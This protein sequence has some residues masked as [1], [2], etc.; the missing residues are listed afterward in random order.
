MKLVL[1]LSG[2]LLIASCKPTSEF[3]LKDELASNNDGVTNDGND[4]PAIPS[5]PIVDP[6]VQPPVVQP[7]VVSPPV[8][9]APPV[10]Q[11]PVVTEPPVVIDPPVVTPPIVVAPPVVTP[12]VV[13]APPV[14]VTPP[15]VVAPPV[16]VTPPV[17]VAPP[18]V[19]APPVI[20]TPPVTQAPIKLVNNTLSCKYSFSA[21]HVGE[22]VNVTIISGSLSKLAKISDSAYSSLSSEDK[23]F[24]AD[25]IAN[26]LSLQAVDGINGNV[27]TISDKFLVQN[28]NN[29]SVNVTR[30]QEDVNLNYALKGDSAS[31]RAT[32][33]AMN[34]K[35]VAVLDGK[36]SS[37]D[38]TSLGKGAQIFLV[39]V[40]QGDNVT[41]IST[42]GVAGNMHSYVYGEDDKITQSQVKATAIKGSSII[43]Y[44]SGMHNTKAFLTG[45]NISNSNV[46][47]KVE[48]LGV[49]SGS[50]NNFTSMGDSNIFN[51]KIKGMDLTNLLVD[52]TCAGKNLVFN[53]DLF[54]QRDTRASFAFT[55]ESNIKIL[56]TMTGTATKLN[57]SER[58][59]DSKTATINVIK[60]AS[61]NV[62]GSL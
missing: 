47:I 4:I 26:K 33:V 2:L 46:N 20:V 42:T 30:I 57:L 62:I 16:I 45:T 44:V 1:C 7:P 38:F 21:T 25:A 41:C 9:V 56:G 5:D 59:L 15:V 40:T 11:P 10:T 53:I 14:V 27:Q 39:Y 55:A 60:N 50:V 22:N 34:S 61:L 24:V 43:Q 18:V 35:I 36:T 52:G 51:V 6:V 19:I 37:V 3:H 31:I 23:M 8:V 49:N 32:A 17:V 13:V 28:N 29:A 48:G 12:P 54:S 58:L